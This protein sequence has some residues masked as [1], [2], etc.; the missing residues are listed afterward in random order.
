M[1]FARIAARTLGAGAVLL[2]GAALIIGSGLFTF[3]RE[4]RIR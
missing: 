4:R 3:W 2:A 1:A